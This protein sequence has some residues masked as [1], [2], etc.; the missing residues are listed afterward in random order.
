MYIYL[1]SFSFTQQQT[2]T[3]SLCSSQ[4][5]Q[6]LHTI[7]MI[8]AWTW[9]HHTVSGHTWL[10]SCEAS[11]ACSVS[12]VSGSFE[13]RQLDASLLPASLYLFWKI[14]QN[15]IFYI[16]CHTPWLQ[17]KKSNL[18]L[19]FNFRGE[20]TDQVG[21]FSDGFYSS[22]LWI[23]KEP[24]AVPHFVF[25][26]QLWQT[27]CRWSLGAASKHW[28]SGSSSRSP[29]TCSGDNKTCSQGYWF[30]CNDSVAVVCFK[31]CM[32]C[33]FDTVFL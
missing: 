5:Q 17:L 1:I 8:Q 30:S 9:T 22:M 6:V 10:C 29:Y 3:V 27:G 33:F 26:K 11:L 18:T 4:Q 24:L 31:V 16:Y 14:R 19:R 15:Q 23:L 2:K 13:Y 12:R 21:H 25:Q 20:G 7:Y 32:S 28:P